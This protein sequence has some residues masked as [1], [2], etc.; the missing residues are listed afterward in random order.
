[1]FS[2]RNLGRVC[3]VDCCYRSRVE[4]HVQFTNRRE[5]PAVVVTDP[6]PPMALRACARVMALSN[7]VRVEVLEDVPQVFGIRNV[8]TEALERRED[9]SVP[10]VSSNALDH[11]REPTDGGEHEQRL[12]VPPGRIG[13]AGVGECVARGVWVTARPAMFGEG[14]VGV[15]Q[16][17]ALELDDAPPE[18]GR[19]RAYSEAPKLVL[20]VFVRDFVHA[21]SVEVVEPWP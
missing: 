5:R 14:Y 10:G 19:R 12:D 17:D 21:R 1:M 3:Q 9:R 20:D 18:G 7:G 16:S 2:P 11:Q 4:V 13:K 8:L 15:A 6:R